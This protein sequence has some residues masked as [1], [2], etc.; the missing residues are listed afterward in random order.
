MAL[1]AGN[2]K[3]IGEICD[4]LGLKHCNYLNINF[5]KNSFARVTARFTP[6]VDGVKQMQSVLK[7]F[8]LVP[9]KEEN[10][11]V[12]MPMSDLMKTVTCEIE[13]TGVRS[14]KVRLAI[15]MVLFKFAAWVTGMKVTIK[16][17]NQTLGEIV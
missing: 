14:W 4:A 16:V 11:G 1:V 12:T 8:H 3:M 15:G 13:L 5:E 9:I 7:D 17:G 10:V 6:E 2:H